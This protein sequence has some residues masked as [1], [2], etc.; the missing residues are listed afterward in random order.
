MKELKIV[1]GWRD[2]P[3]MLKY[4]DLL[5]NRCPTCGHNLSFHFKLI[6]EWE[7]DTIST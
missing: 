3:D 6:E 1:V 2:D 7:I 5:F 4:H